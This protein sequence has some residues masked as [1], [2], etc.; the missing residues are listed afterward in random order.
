MSTHNIVT[1]LKD[2]V[3]SGG[4]ISREDA[5]QLAAWPDREAVWSAAE[6]ITR[7]MCP[8]Q[9]DSCSIVNA[10]SGRCPEN[11]KWCAQSA[12]YSTGC[13]SY[14]IIGDEECMAE[15]RHNHSKG[16]KRFSLVAS[17]R[18][19]RGESLTHICSLLRR[20]K[21]EV[22]ISTCASLGLIGHD[23]LMALREAGVCR[24]HCNLET[25]PSHFAT[26]CTTH[27]VDDKLATIRMAHELGFEVCSGGIIGMGE[28]P[29]QR[30][31]FAFTLREADP[32]SIPVNILCPI[33][34]TPLES[35]APLTDEE[36]LDTVAMM[37]FVHPRV[38]IRF[39]GG[40]SRMSRATQLRAM[41]IAVNGGI[42]GDLLTT[43]GSQIDD[44]R[45]LTNEAGYEF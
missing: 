33:P 32:V 44:D 17:G 42:V 6:E 38:Q 30:I 19:V 37:R 13:Q 3:L 20:V 27:T 10:R 12:H 34:G 40:R 2:K 35:A 15:A 9:F 14:E 39:A 7:E 11:C 18:A 24:Y 45:R 16:V 4:S 31:E 22:G 21:E 25:A 36:I 41:R 28:S 29:Q 1:E 26:L 23:E 5:E 43:V 8:R